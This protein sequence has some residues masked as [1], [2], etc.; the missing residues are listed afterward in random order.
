MFDLA[1]EKEKRFFSR[2]TKVPGQISST[3]QA[4]YIIGLVRA[5]KQLF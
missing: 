3:Q 2:H 5:N 1:D 4:K